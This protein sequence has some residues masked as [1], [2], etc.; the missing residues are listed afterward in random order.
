M[1]K[2]A[3]TK[4]SSKREKGGGIFPKRIPYAIL[5]LLMGV[6]T[7]ALFYAMILVDVFPK[8]LTLLIIGIVVGLLAVTSILLARRKRWKRLLGII[9]GA[10]FVVV[11]G[12]V[13][14]YLGTTYATM[15]K[16][17]KIANT[18]NAEMGTGANIDPTTEAF[19]LYITGI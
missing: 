8:D 15:T 3:E 2:E 13:T 4:H 9:I 19:T 12:S 17:S 5:V 6:A 16:I 10:L 1:K 11:I 18:S 14:Y 7:I